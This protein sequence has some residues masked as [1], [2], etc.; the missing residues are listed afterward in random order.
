MDIKL[1]IFVIKSLVSKSYSIIRKSYAYII[2]LLK[3]AYIINLF[4]YFNVLDSEFLL[5]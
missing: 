3:Y 4:S 5:H 1:P 2:N